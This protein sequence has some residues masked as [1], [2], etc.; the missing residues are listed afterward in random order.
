MG[1]P[2][3]QLTG[4]YIYNATE[5]KL[6]HLIWEMKHFCYW[7]HLFKNV[8]KN[9]FNRAQ[10]CNKDLLRRIIKKADFTLIKG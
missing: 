4:F 7:K 5:I 1:H 3:Y 9:I 2:V 8:L 6:N 10:N